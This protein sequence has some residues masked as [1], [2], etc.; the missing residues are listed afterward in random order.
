MLPGATIPARHAACYQ[1]KC[2]ILQQRLQQVASILAATVEATV[3][4]P[5]INWQHLARMATLQSCCHV[6]PN[7]ATLAS[8]VAAKRC[9]VQQ[10]PWSQ[11]LASGLAAPGNTCHNFRQHLAAFVAA[12]GNNWH[13]FRQYLAALG[14]SFEGT[15]QQSLQKSLQPFWRHLAAPGS[16]PGL[17]P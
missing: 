10:K 6:L 7:A 17:L 3:A 1:Q 11:H 15:C 14:S 13:E 9:K 4:A 12:P 16:L 5:C 8:R 2:F